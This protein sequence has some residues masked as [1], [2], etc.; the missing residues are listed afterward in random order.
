[1]TTEGARRGY[2]Q[3][4]G[5]R[6]VGG[7]DSRSRRQIDQPPFNTVGSLGGRRDQGDRIPGRARLPGYRR[8]HAV[9]RRGRRTPFQCRPDNPWSW[10]ARFAV[11]GRASGLPEFRYHNPS[12]ERP[13]GRTTVRVRVDRFA[14]TVHAAHGPRGRASPENGS[15]HF[16]CR[17]RWYG[18]V[19]GSARGSSPS[20]SAICDAGSQ[21]PSQVLCTPC[22]VVRRFG[23]HLDRTRS[24]SGSHGV[25]VARDGRACCD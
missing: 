14:P 4:S 23:N 24:D 18:A 7:R 20:G 21:C 25:H 8:H 12:A 19:A 2:T 15:V 16:R 11:P 6:G 10:P 17:R 9:A 13:H 1:M 3:D 5:R 22:R